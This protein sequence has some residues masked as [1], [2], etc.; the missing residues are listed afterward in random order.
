MATCVPIT[1]VVY[2]PQSIIYESLSVLRESKNI[3]MTIGVRCGIYDINGDILEDSTTNVRMIQ[4]AKYVYDTVNIYTPAMTLLAKTNQKC[5]NLFTSEKTRRMLNSK[6]S[7]LDDH[8]KLTCAYMTPFSIND[9]VTRT[10]YSN[11]ST[12][13]RPLTKARTELTSLVLSTISTTVNNPI[14]GFNRVNSWYVTNEYYQHD[15]DNVIEDSAGNIVQKNWSGI[16]FHKIMTGKTNPT[17]SEITNGRDRYAAELYKSVKL[18]YKNNV[19]TSYIGFGYRF[20]ELPELLKTHLDKARIIN[21]IYPGVVDGFAYQGHLK[22]TSDLNIMEKSLNIMRNEGYK[23]CISEFDC[24]LFDTNIL[25]TYTN[26][27]Y[28]N[29]FNRPTLRITKVGKYINESSSEFDDL[30]SNQSNI[31]S[32]FFKICLNQGVS[33]FI[34]YDSSDRYGWKD[35]FHNHIHYTQI[36]VGSTWRN[37]QVG[38]IVLEAIEKSLWGPY[39]TIEER[40]SS[41]NGTNLYRAV[42]QYNYT[43]LFDKNYNP[44]PCYYGIL[45]VL[46]NYNLADYDSRKSIYGAKSVLNYGYSDA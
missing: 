38:D 6:F 23:V 31:Y 44:K 2:T 28:D 8:L 19:G 3:P 40:L 41:I 34:Y 42:L 24:T 16:E 33:D 13:T 46:N 39:I 4:N 26:N 14:S 30:L 11:I 5:L 35:D 22:V 36:K 32:D 12:F 9:P 27:G 20:D 25:Q 10:N 45:N 17:F 15:D 43:T 29:T 1:P 18:S 7:F 21:G 37:I